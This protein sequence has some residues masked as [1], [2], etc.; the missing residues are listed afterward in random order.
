MGQKGGKGQ[1]KG[2]DPKKKHVNKEHVFNEYNV[3]MV[4]DFNGLQC[5]YTNADSLPNKLGEL[6]TRILFVIY[7]NDMPECVDSTIYL[8]ADDNKILREIKSPNDEEKLQNDLDELQKWSDTWLLKFHPNKC[9]VPTVSNRKM[10]EKEA[11]NYH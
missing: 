9:K 4:M 2:L 1:E 10:A 5:Y 3:N 6:K 8:F 7:I 11:K